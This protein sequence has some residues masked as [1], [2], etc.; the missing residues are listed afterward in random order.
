MQAYIFEKNDELINYDRL[1]II[2]DYSDYEDSVYAV[3]WLAS[4]NWDFA[5]VTY[6]TI[7]QI[8]SIPTDIKFKLMV[9]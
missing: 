4:D 8:N 3:E 6:N 9:N 1:K 7:F 5:T 2:V